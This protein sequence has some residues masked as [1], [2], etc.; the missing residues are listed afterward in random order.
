MKPATWQTP[1]SY[2]SGDDDGDG[3]LDTA[4]SIFEDSF[5]ETWVF[6]CSTT[7]TAT[8]TN[9]VGVE[10]SPVDPEGGALCGPT[11][12]P[13]LT[14]EPCDVDDSDKATVTVSGVLPEDLAGTGAPPGI[15]RQIAIGLVLVLLGASLLLRRRKPVLPG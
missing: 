10:G 3:L 13:E 6:T 9:T 2:V 14:S 5:D 7:V 12:G 4:D 15:G 11:A 8:T 1:V